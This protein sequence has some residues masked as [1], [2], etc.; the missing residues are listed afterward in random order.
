MGFA[1]AGIGAGH[2]YAGFR[3]QEVHIKGLHI[4]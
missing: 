3:R 1:D 2:E 4:A